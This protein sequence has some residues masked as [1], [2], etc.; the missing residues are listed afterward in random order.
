MISTAAGVALRAQFAQAQHTPLPGV[1]G[2]S[3]IAFE[4]M[5]AS[6][7]PP[8]GYQFAAPL[9]GHQFGASE[10]PRTPNKGKQ[11]ADP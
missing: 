8:A 11:R 7:T 2:P 5:Q 6:S 1:A 10:P 9:A 4:P 3:S